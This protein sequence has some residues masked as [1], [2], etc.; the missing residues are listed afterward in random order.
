MLTQVHSLSL[1]FLYPPVASYQWKRSVLLT[2]C[3]EVELLLKLLTKNAVE[4][5][6][7]LPL[8]AL[9]IQNTSVFHTH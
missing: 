9:L 1:Q 5:V 6:D 3:F 4:T 8:S 7:L 2:T